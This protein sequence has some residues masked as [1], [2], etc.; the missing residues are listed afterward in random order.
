MYGAVCAVR[1]A[2]SVS[3]T[4]APILAGGRGAIQPWLAQAQAPQ[5]NAGAKSDTAIKQANPANE[6]TGGAGDKKGDKPKDLG[7]SDA[8]WW[9]DSPIDIFTGALVVV[10]IGLIAT[11]YCTIRTMQE[12][13]RRQL[14]AYVGIVQIEIEAP[15]MPH[16]AFEIPNPAPAGFVHEDFVNVTVKNYG[17]TL[18]SEVLVWMN[19]LPGPFGSQIADEFQY[20]DN[21]P[22]NTAAHASR[23]VVNINALAPFRRAARRETTLHFYGHVDYTDIYERRHRRDFCFIYEPWRP[24]SVRFVP[25][26]RHNRE[27]TIARNDPGIV[28]PP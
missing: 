3:V 17:Q 23:A 8:A 16:A 6:S 2:S 27:Y 21:D 14:R 1:G 15:H 22:L 20:P 11:G 13:E 9:F 25:A 5:Q 7:P 19:W 28:P 26:P 12:T 18:A 4:A 10:T 24:Q